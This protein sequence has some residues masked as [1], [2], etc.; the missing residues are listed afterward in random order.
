M[1]YYT[2]MTL[3]EINEQLK[4]PGRSVRWLANELEMNEAALGQILLGKRPLKPTLAKHIAFVLGQ[5]EC[6][7][8][9][10]VNASTQKV[11]ELTA[12]KGCTC[13]RDRLQ[14]M[15]GIIAHNME[16]LA[17]AGANVGWTP[18]QLAAWGVE[19]PEAAG[20]D[21]SAPA[22]PYQEEKRPFA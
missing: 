5:R 14:A 9:Y 11:E 13:E 4:A 17:K 7:F 10:K 2:R 3:D 21:A 1:Y 18:E 20:A 8:V 22:K 6:I 19:Q 15:Q 12:G 16:L